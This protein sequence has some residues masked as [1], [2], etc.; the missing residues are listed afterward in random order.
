MLST[1][2]SRYA[3]ESL[4]VFKVYSVKTAMSVMPSTEDS[5]III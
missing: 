2:D 3:S 4:N 1:E 5:K